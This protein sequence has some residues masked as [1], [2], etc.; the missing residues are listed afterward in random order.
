M[1]VIGDLS[2]KL[3]EICKK[4][5]ATDHEIKPHAWK[6]QGSPITDNIRVENAEDTW[7]RP[8]YYSA[9]REVKFTS[10]L[11]RHFFLPAPSLRF[12]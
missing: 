3:Q 4:Q 6:L 9:R 1:A 12:A 5:R 8:I 7:D 10:I 11:C 2:I